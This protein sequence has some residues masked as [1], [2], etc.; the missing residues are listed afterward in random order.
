MSITANSTATFL[1]W[2]P[3]YAERGIATFPVGDNKVPAIRSYQRVGRR[4]SGQLASKFPDAP[5]IGFM[6]GKRSGITVLDVDSKDE[7]VLADALDRHG[8]TQ[9]VVRSGGGNFQAWYRHNSERRR[10]RPDRSVP[11]DVLGDGYVVA[12]ASRVAKGQYQFIQGNLD[13]LDRLP[14]MEGIPPISPESVD[15]SGICPGEIKQG[16]RNKR[17]FNLCLHAARHCDE[18]DTLCDVAKTRNS[19][20]VP[21]LEDDEVM[22]VAASAWRYETEGRNY[23]GGMCAVLS[24]GDVL[25]LMPDP[26]VAALIVWAKASFKPDSEFW[27]ADGLAEKFGWSARQLRQAR[28]R[29]IQTGL[30]RLIRP[31]GFK[32]AAVYGFG[33]LSHLAPK[34]SA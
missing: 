1:N 3:S 10:I 32:R 22:K 9:I 17:L 7:R 4:G 12:P 27:I 15:F 8:K 19:E 14:V 24:V 28:R 16:E 13:D 30:I 31:A 20:L 11:I 2:Q 18:F 21:P 29:A 5:A 33:A 23:S 25:P 34:G 6:C 26:Y